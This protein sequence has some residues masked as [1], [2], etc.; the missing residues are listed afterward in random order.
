MIGKLISYILL[1][2]EALLDLVASANIFP[3]IINED[4]LLPAIVYTIDSIDP[5]YAKDSEWVMDTCRF[6]IKTYD[7]KYA[8]LQDIVLAIRQAVEFQQGTVNGFTLDRIELIGQNE[9]Y[10][11]TE[12]VYFNSLQ[13]SV[14]IKGY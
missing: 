13:F 4:T 3:Y 11:I 12:G 1:N 2:D 6:T 7:V 5:V 10:E 9:G 14:N 8:N